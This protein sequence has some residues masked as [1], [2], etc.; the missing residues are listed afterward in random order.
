MR[1]ETTGLLALPDLRYADN[2]SI[3]SVARPPVA[4]QKL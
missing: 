4:S 1:Y 3:V 2:P